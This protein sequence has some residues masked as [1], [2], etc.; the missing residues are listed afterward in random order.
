MLE[1]QIQDDDLAA[2]NELPKAGAYAERL[3]TADI[4]GQE[5]DGGVIRRKSFCETF[6]IAESTLSTWLHTDRI[7]RVAAVAYVLWLAFKK[8]RDEI[9]Q[10]DELAAER[11]VIRCREGYAVVQ[12]KHNANGIEVGHVIASGIETAE[13]AREFIIYRKE[14]NRAV[15]YLRAYAEQFVNE[16]ENG[17]ADCADALE[18][19]LNFDIDP[20]TSKIVPPTADQL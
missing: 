13:S 9:K 1:L 6:G 14:A 19:T 18:R 5:F 7:P 11:F 15:E 3:L 4:L 16:G 17:P 8:Q 12:P 20:P 2:L 10:R